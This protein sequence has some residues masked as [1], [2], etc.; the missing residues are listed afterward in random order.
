MPGIMM[1]SLSALNVALID[2]ENIMRFTT[3]DHI[4]KELTRERSAYP[5]FDLIY[6]AFGVFTTAVN[7]L[8]DELYGDQDPG[9]VYMEAIRAGAILVRLVEDCILDNPEMFGKAMEAAA[10]HYRDEYRNNAG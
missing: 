2:K 8:R 9:R 3:E 4:R 10:R 7:R 1:M 6:Q 5:K